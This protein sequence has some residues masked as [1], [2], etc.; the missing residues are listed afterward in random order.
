[1]SQAS[2]KSFLHQI[3]SGKR[4][5][6]QMAIY[7]YIKRN[8]K[9]TIAE[10]DFHTSISYSTLTARVSDLLDMGIIKIVGDLETKV[11]VYSK[12][13]I[14]TDENEQNKLFKERKKSKRVKAIMH[15]L[16]NHENQLTEELKTELRKA[17]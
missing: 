7:K 11:G 17:I 3:N 14:V 6:H 5:S 2:I 13:Q 1:M 16:N 12:L 15:L 10:M 9:S 8:P 4:D